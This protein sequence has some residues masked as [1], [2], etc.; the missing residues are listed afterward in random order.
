[1]NISPDAFRTPDSIVDAAAP[2]AGDKEFRHVSRPYY[3]SLVQKA[4]EELAMDTFFLVEDEAFDMP[5][6]LI[7]AMPERSFNIRQLYGFNGDVCNAGTR[8]NIYH[9]RNYIATGNENF[10]ARDKGD[11]PRDPFYQRRGRALSGDVHLTNALTA[12]GFLSDVN[13]PRT[14]SLGTTVKNLFFYEVRRGKIHFSPA[15]KSLTKY[16]V[17]FNGLGEE[18]GSK[19]IVPIFL[20]EAVTDFV[21]DGA[22]RVMFAE[23][24][25]RWAAIYQVQNEK[26]TGGRRDFTGT[27][28]KAEKRIKNIDSKERE[29]LKEYYSKLNA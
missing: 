13:N 10:F 8:V 18:M 16:L 15:C 27:W 17:V 28:Y 24:P 1:M 12:N 19:A 2:L 14:R 21:A 4:L 3:M 7:A 23:S 6:S 29:D 25:A 26:L 9:K 22:L 11:N 20:R 5:K